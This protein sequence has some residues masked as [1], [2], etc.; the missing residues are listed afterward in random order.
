[1]LGSSPRRVGGSDQR[2]GWRARVAGARE[3]ARRLRERRLRRTAGIA[4]LAGAIATV[5]AVVA[6]NISRAHRGAARKPGRLVAATRSSPPLPSPVQLPALERCQWR[7]RFYS[8]VQATR[9]MAHGPGSVAIGQGDP[10][11]TPAT[12]AQEDLIPTH[13]TRRGAWAGRQEIRPSPAPGCR[14]AEV[15]RS[16]LT[17]PLALHPARGKR[18]GSTQPLQRIPARPL[19]PQLVLR[20]RAR[21]REDTPSS[22]S[23]AE[24]MPGIPGT[25]V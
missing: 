24:R 4:M 20:W 25:R 14:A 11:F 13:A 18:F 1:M 2:W 6:A 10:F 12:F 8:S 7:R 3:N 19:A 5:G 22:D 21:K 15:P 16:S 9:L 17:I 23:S